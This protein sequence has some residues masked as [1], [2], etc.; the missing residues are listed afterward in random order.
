MPDNLN[1]NS[2][3]VV[4]YFSRLDGAPQGTKRELSDVTSIGVDGNAFR[5]EALRA[6]A[7]DGESLVYVAS[8]PIADSIRVIYEAL[9]SN[10]VTINRVSMGLA[11]ADVMVLDVVVA[12]FKPI[13]YAAFVILPDGSVS[14]GPAVEVRARWKFQYAG[15]P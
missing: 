7:F 1:Y 8:F 12:Q 4:T 2:G 14:S 11:H 9:V 13:V 15:V 3:A 10:L 5:L 6:P